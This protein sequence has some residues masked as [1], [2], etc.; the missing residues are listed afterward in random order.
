AGFN[1]LFDKNNIHRQQCPRLAIY[2]HVGE[3]H[4][5]TNGRFT[6]YT[7]ACQYVLL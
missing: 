7:L 2:V 6:Y 1:Q 4:G 3:F 5:D